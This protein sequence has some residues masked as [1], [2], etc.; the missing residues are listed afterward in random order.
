[1]QHSIQQELEQI[2]DRGLYR[3]TRMITGTQGS[4]VEMDGR[5]VLMLCSNNY[6]GL[7][8]SPALIRAAVEATERYGTSSGA[9]RLVSGTMALHEQLEAEVAAFKRSEAALIFNSGYAA[10]TGI[11]AALAGR[12]DVILSDRLNHASI[13]D[14]ALLSSARLIRY[15]HTDVPA[16]EALLKQH[17]GTGRALIVTDAVFSM[18]GDIAPLRELVELKTAHNA[19]LMVDD[20]HGS[21]V[22]GADG[23]GTAELFGVAG[24]VDILMGTFGKA[25]GS[26]GAYAAVSAELRELLVNRARSFIFSTS[27]PPAVLGASLAALKLVRSPEGKALRQKLGSN[28]DRFRALLAEAGFNLPE[29]RTQIIPVLTGQADATMRFSGMLLEEGIFAQGI[30]P[31]TVPA[32]ACRLRFTVMATHTPE[33]LE[34]AAGRVSNVGT[35]LGVI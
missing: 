2:R 13:V 28:A 11:I 1:V 27:L 25:L 9:S 17:R 32:G 7:A 14:G 16:L 18:D 10:N 20:A 6:L 35:H 21:G 34:W 3:S 19:L 31:P 30:R 15:P 29:G 24:D 8:D 12:G 26:F 5:D 4:H 33:E 23:S 22:L